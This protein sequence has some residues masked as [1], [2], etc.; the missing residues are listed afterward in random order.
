MGENS[1]NIQN[2]VLAYL[3]RQKAGKLSGPKNREKNLHIFLNHLQEK[4]GRFLQTGC[5][6][7]CKK[8]K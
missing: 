8:N 3:R 4:L 6:E 1:T 7:I 5:S 2:K